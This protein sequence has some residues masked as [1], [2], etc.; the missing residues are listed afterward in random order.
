MDVNKILQDTFKSTLLFFTNLFFVVLILLCSLFNY[1]KGEIKYF[2][3]NKN[4]GCFKEN[5]Y[6]QKDN[7]GEN[8]DEK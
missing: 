8:K 6:I 3:S 4:Y 1:I 5:T 7:I 2:L